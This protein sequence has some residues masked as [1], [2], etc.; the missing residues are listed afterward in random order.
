VERVDFFVV[1]WKFMVFGNFLGWKRISG[2]YRILSN[3]SACTK[4]LEIFTL[5]PLFLYAKMD[6]LKLEM[7]YN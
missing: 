7:H 1:E 2:G 3:Y 5:V 6:A 4:I